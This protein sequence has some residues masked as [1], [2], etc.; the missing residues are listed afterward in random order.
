M[1]NP[2]S[3]LK[4]ET[5]KFLNDFEI[6]TDYLISLWRPDQQQ[7]QQQKTC[8]I[9]DF[10]VPAENRIKIQKLEKRD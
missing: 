9:K 5:H 4:N 1:Y 2:E 7:Q 8:I 6:Q 10:T 3:T